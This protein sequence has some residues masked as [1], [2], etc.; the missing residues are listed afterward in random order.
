MSVAANATG[1]TSVRMIYAM[2]MLAVSC[3]MIFEVLLPEAV[4]H[5]MILAGPVSFVM[6]LAEMMLPVYTEFD[7]AGSS[8]V[9]LGCRR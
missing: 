1:A 5:A 6:M 7:W 4:S 8:M 2:V 3:A 9:C